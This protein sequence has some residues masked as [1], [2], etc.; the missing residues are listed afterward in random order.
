VRLLAVGRVE[1]V[2]GAAGHH[3]RVLVAVTVDAVAKRQLEEHHLGRTVER[4]A[5][6]DVEIDVASTLVPVPDVAGLGGIIEAVRAVTRSAPAG[7]IQ[8]V[9][10]FASRRAARLRA[11]TA[12]VFSR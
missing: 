1:V 7:V 8:A 5:D 9:A 4:V 12:V 11:R 2:L 10:T 3:E 6:H